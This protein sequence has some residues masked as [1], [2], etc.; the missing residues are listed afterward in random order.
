[1]VDFYRARTPLSRHG[2]LTHP[3]PSPSPSPTPRRGKTRLA[4]SELGPKTPSRS[5]QVYDDSLPRSSQPQTPA[6]LPEA[7]HQSRFHPSYTAPVP[8]GVTRRAVSRV[9]GT[10]SG[11]RRGPRLDRIQ[12]LSTPLRRGAGRSAS[13]M[14]MSQGGFTG[15]F[16]GRENGDEEHNWAEGVRFSYAETRLWGLRD[17]RNDG[18]S[19][20]ETPEPEDWR[21]GRRG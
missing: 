1:M 15:L 17:A 3:S 11:D 7:R 18:S 13:P 19:L 21:V 10:N 5:Y 14:G 8:R 9:D 2:S 6:Y 20:R 16:G 4:S 12:Q